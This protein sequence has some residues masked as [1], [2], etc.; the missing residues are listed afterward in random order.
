MQYLKDGFKHGLKP[1]F[2]L[3]IFTKTKQ[4]FAQYFL[5][6]RYSGIKEINFVYTNLLKNEKEIL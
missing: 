6:F 5:I 4:N 3:Q 2:S 1:S